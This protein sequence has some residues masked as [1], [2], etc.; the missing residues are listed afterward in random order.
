MIVATLG[1][2]V[3][4]A[5]RRG[6]HPVAEARRRSVGLHP[7]WLMFALLAFGVAVRLRRPAPGRA[8]RRG[9]R[10][11]SPASRLRQY[12][13]EPALSRRRPIPADHHARRSISMR[14]TSAGS[15]PSTCRSIR[16]SAARISSSAPS[17]EQAYG[18][19]RE[20]AGLAATRSWCSSVRAAAAR[21]IWRRSGRPTAHAW[22]VDAFE[23]AHDKVPHLVSNG[24]LAI[25]DV[26][27]AERDEAALFHLLNLARE[28]AGLRA[29]HLREA[30][31]PMGP[32]H[33]RSPV[34]P[35]PGAE[36]VARTRRTMRC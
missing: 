11:R 31:R 33:A 35:A 10:R 5:V 2:F 26:D 23:V 15:S 24:A 7:V 34:A 30:A 4:R 17:N 21:A 28:T 13:D 32:A 20:L 29:A 36:R 19:D 27:R 25:E 12:L 1:I 22:T 16:A 18:A 3:V 14:E 6:Q 9:R 8:A